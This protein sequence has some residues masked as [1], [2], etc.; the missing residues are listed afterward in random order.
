MRRIDS[1]EPVIAVGDFNVPRDS[2]LF[3][4][5]VAASGLQDAFDGDAS[6]TYRPVPGW[7]ERRWTR[8]WCRQGCRSRPKWC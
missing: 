5:F 8:C 1:G 6:T 3:E 4:G 7:D 2:W